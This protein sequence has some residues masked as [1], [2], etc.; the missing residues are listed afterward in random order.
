MT[1]YAPVFTMPITKFCP[2]MKKIQQAFK[3]SGKMPAL[4]TIALPGSK[5]IS[6]SPTLLIIAST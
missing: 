1:F 6:V 3:P 2:L 4:P 5:I